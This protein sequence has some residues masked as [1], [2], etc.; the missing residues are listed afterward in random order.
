[1]VA[2]GRDATPR[3]RRQV[4]SASGW[5]WSK[6]V[7]YSCHQR[8]VSGSPRR[9]QSQIGRPLASA[10]KSISPVPMSRSVTSHD[11][12]LDD[13]VPHASDERLDARRS[14][15]DLAGVVTA[16]VGRRPQ[17]LVLLGERDGIP[18]G[19]QLLQEDAHV[20][21]SLVRFVDAVVPHGLIVA[22]LGAVASNP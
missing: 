21:Q 3:I 1:M 17:L 2:L 18:V 4:S 20:G 13:G 9:Q 5:R 22:H 8:M 15:S 12:E 14:R 16:A 6:P 11:I 7:S 10:G 19:S